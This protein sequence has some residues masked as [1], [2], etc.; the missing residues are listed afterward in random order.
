MKAFLLGLSLLLFGSNVLAQSSLQIDKLQ[1]KSIQDAGT[2][3]GY[4]SVVEGTVSD[5]AV[6][7]YVFVYQPY[8]KAWR[9]FPASIQEQAG[10]YRW[11]ALCHFGKADGTGVGASYQI[12]ALGFEKGQIPAE[13]LPKNISP[14]VLKSNAIVLKRTK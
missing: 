9:A 6:T 8:L 3:I 11:R 5:P 2:E 12:K 7:V 1:R 10:G 13:G 4:S 14:T